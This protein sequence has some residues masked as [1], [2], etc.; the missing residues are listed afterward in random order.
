MLA[1]KRG[2]VAA[3]Q[4]GLFLLNRELFPRKLSRS[5]GRTKLVAIN[6]SYK[7]VPVQ[8]EDELSCIGAILGAVRDYIRLSR[9]GVLSPTGADFLYPQRPK[10]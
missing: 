10:L 3:N 2:P 8:P 4:L 9:G 1:V 6:I 7:D 5:P